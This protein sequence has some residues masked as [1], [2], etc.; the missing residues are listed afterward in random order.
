MARNW[1][2]LEQLSRPSSQTTWVKV[3]SHCNH[4][5]TAN[6]KKVSYVLLT[7]LISLRPISLA[8]VPVQLAT[9]QEKHAEQRGETC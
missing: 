9:A 6:R 1:S 4:S 2:V 3:K 7:C 8:Q 5:R